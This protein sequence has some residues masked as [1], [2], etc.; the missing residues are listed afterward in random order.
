MAKR[1]RL[2]VIDALSARLGSPKKKGQESDFT[3]P[4]CIKAGIHPPSK[5][6]VN[7]NKR[8][9]HNGAMYHGAA[10]CHKCGYKTRSMY[11]LL[12]DVLGRVPRIAFQRVTQ[13]TEDIVKIVE[14]IF[15]EDTTETIMLPEEFKRL[16]VPPRGV[17]AKLMYSWLTSPRPFGRRLTDDDIDDWGL[18]YCTKGLYAGHV[19]FPLYM[20][21]E[22][23]Y[24]TSRAFIS[25]TS[26]SLHP[27]GSRDA[28]LYGYD[29]AATVDDWVAVVEGPMDAIAFGEHGIGL[30]GQNLSR[31][32]RRLL[33][34]VQAKEIIVALD[35]DA[36]DRARELAAELAE[37]TGKRVS[38]LPFEEGDPDDHRPHLEEM[39]SQRV[40]VDGF[41]DMV[42]QLLGK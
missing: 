5:L 14:E 41:L 26:K 39:L 42:E 22:M 20:N 13:Q 7:P 16:H 11:N 37:A 8:G 28:F 9:R 10:L 12:R 40:E 27:K 34:R 1:K 3:C 35:A 4:F 23:V 24:F 29:R 36:Q 33:S 17:F 31:Q 30:L 38:Y 19:I 15:K 6:H 21:G 25:S 32:Q 2:T 18:G